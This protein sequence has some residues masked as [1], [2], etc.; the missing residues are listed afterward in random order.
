MQSRGDFHIIYI[1]K[2]A[3]TFSFSESASAYCFLCFIR[4]R[5]R[6]SYE[7]LLESRFC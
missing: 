2:S 4:I 1:Y 6:V 3:L 5:Y 7:Y